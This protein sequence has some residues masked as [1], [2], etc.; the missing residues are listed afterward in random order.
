[1]GAGRR[2]STLASKCPRCGTTH[3]AKNLTQLKRQIFR[4]CRKTKG[5]RREP[6]RR[7][8]C[9]LTKLP[10]IELPA[11]FCFARTVMS[12]NRTTYSHWTVHSRDHKD[13]RKRV[14]HALRTLRGAR[15]AWSLWLIERVYGP[16][17]REFDFANLVGGAKPLV[18]SL[19]DLDV[20][21]D[22]SPAHFECAYDQ[23][24]GEENMTRLTLKEFK[25]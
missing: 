13:W 25:R 20:I 5:K 19:I 7:Q 2:D 23:F 21:E 3:R 6:I 4:C 12:Q 1:M 17:N 22:D 24:R 11:T 16:R 8:R 15:F 10:D 9:R 18:D 14:S